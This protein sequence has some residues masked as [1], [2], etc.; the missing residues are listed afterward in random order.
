MDLQEEFS[1]LVYLYHQ[2]AEGKG[3]STQE[4]FRQ[5]TAFMEHLKT[6]LAAG[7]EEDRAEAVL[8]MK[9]LHKEMRILTKIM[10][11]KAG[12][13]EEELIAGS[14]NPANYTPSQWQELQESKQ[15]LAQAGENLTQ[16]IQGQNPKAPESP[17]KPVKKRTKKSHWLRS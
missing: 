3:G 4:L 9:E 16:E 10:A 14:E 5:S 1:R 11:D 6:Q 2:A 12:V 7:D 15:R 13:S 17:K 8:M